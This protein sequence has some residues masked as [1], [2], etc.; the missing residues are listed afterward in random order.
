M[1]FMHS[2]PFC[3]RYRGRVSCFWSKIQSSIYIAFQKL[4]FLMSKCRLKTANGSLLSRWRFKVAFESLV[5]RNFG[6][7]THA[8][9]RD[10]YY[11][12]NMIILD[13]YVW[14][15][16]GLYW[17]VFMKC[18]LVADMVSFEIIGNRFGCLV[19]VKMNIFESVTKMLNKS[20]IC[21]KWISCKNMC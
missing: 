2:S 17:T 9:H 12:R 4:K 10:L 8:D 11:R 18:W 7:Q 20:E 16:C 14:L 21:F 6:R 13:D 3:D 19:L 15:H 5:N 1:K